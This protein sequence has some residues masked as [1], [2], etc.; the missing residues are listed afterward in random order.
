M[1]KYIN[2]CVIIFWKKEVIKMGK[3]KIKVTLK[4]N[5]EESIN[6]YIAIK[7]KNKLI[8]HDNEYK[9][10]ISNL[11]SLKL[12]RENLDSLF[13]MEFIQNK[14]TKG[15]C[16]LKKQNYQIEL[17]ILTDYVIIK[18]DNLVI[19]YKVLTTNQE[20]LYKLEVLK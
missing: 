11:N 7:D 9:V 17:D 13:E 14:K 10:I 5:N 16:L 1:Y 19:K 6:E 12:K 2:I 4:S 8:Y 3:I 15:I 20:V 18:D